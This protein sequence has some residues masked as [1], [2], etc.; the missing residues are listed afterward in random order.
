M[1][2]KNLASP[3]PDRIKSEHLKYLPPVLIT[4][5]RLLTRYLTECK[6]PKQW[7]TS[8]TVLWYKKGDPHEIGSYR[9]I[10]LLLL[11]ADWTI[12]STSSSQE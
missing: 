7:K 11:R 4:L 8:K 2:V 10:C 1:S 9:P 3:G 12:Q 5:E 6:V